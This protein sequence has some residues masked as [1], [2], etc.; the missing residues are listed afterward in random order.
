MLQARSA[1]IPF[2][3]KKRSFDLAWGAWAGILAVMTA[4]GAALTGSQILMMY[5]QSAGFLEFKYPSLPRSDEAS[6]R[7]LGRDTVTFFW[8][9]EGLVVGRIA[10]V[11]AP[12]GGSQLLLKN[13]AP[14]SLISVRVELEKWLR[15]HVKAP[16]RVIAV[17]ESVRKTSKI[18]FS[19]MAEL[20]GLMEGLNQSVFREEVR[21]ALVRVD[22]VNP[23]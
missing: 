8:G 18:T 6:A 2:Q 20:A 16:V 19:E 22:L 3:T 13:P 9:T 5:P 21:P 11:I 23:L 17:G 14:N 12:Q 15:S 1:R 7:Q 4:V 10:D